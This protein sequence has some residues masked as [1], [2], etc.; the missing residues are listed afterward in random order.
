MVN[1]RDININK[2]RMKFSELFMKLA[3][4]WLGMIPGLGGGFGIVG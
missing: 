3:A 4:P 2:M 1:D